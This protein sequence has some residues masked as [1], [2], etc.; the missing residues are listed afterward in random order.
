MPTY[1][2]FINKKATGDFVTGTTAEDAYMN[3]ASR[4]PLSYSDDVQLA[5]VASS[6]SQ[7]QDI[8]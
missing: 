5:E 4:F 1:R 6:E 8:G 7:E 2:V 3:V